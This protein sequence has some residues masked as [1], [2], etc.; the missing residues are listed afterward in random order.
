MSEGADSTCFPC[1]QTASDPLRVN[2]LPNGTVCPTCRERLLDSLDGPLPADLLRVGEVRPLTDEDE[3][4][5]SVL[6]PRHLVR[7]GSL[8]EESGSD[9]DYDDDGDGA[10]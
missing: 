6:G 2:H 10:A 9:D 1:G 3:P 5:G 8:R 4:D 7:G